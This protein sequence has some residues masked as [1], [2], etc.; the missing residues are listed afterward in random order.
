[1]CGCAQ[2]WVWKPEGSPWLSVRLALGEDSVLVSKVDDP[3][4][5]VLVFSTA[6][7]SAFLD[8]A[9]RGEFDLGDGGFADAERWGRKS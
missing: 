8:G 1:M 5:G 4:G 7:W 9:R 3:D 2:E 6:E